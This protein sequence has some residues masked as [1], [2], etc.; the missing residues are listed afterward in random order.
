MKKSKFSF[1]RV[2]P[3]IGA[4][5]LVA[6][7]AAT[8]FSQ[9]YPVVPLQSLSQ[10]VGTWQGQLD[11][12]GGSGVPLTITITQ[13]GKYIH[14]KPEKTLRGKVKVKGGKLIVY[15]QGGPWATYEFRQEGKNQELVGDTDGGASVV[16]SRIAT[17]PIPPP[18]SATGSS[19]SATGPAAGADGFLNE[20]GIKSLL[21]G[22][23]IKFGLRERGLVLYFKNDS[24]L[25]GIV[26]GR[27]R[28]FKKDWWV[29]NG[30]IFCRKFGKQNKVHCARVKP[31]GD[32]KVTFVNPK[33]KFTYTATLVDGRKLPE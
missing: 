24:R 18:A 27:G 13:G 17:A 14:E 26:A 32:G 15:R 3:A 21:V 33:G 22:K 6:L 23:T 20:G 2:F 25:E 4:A 28:T 12:P 1:H 19:A 11:A 31:A 7:G 10:V 8:V 16:V 9:T 5:A 29:K 30:N